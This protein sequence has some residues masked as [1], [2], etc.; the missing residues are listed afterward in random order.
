MNLLDVDLEKSCESLCVDVE[1][2]LSSKQVLINRKGFCSDAGLVTKKRRYPLRHIFDD[3][4]RVLFI[5][6]SVAS[7]YVYEDKDGISALIIFALGLSSINLFL[8][9]ASKRND[10]AKKTKHIYYSTVKRDG[11]IKRIHNEDLVPGDILLLKK[12][13]YVPCD[14][15]IISMDELRVL[16]FG[17]GDKIATADKLMYQQVK[18]LSPDMAEIPYHKC[19]LFAD[20][21]VING[22][23]EAIVMNT[24]SDIYDKDGNVRL[25]ADD[26]MPKIYKNAVFISKQLSVIW[27]LMALLYFASGIFF[28]IDIF[29]SFR[30][31][32]V[33]AVASASDMISGICEIALFRQIRKLSDK[34]VYIKRLS[35]LDFLGDVNCITLHSSA[36]LYNG[37]FYLN[38]YLAD[39]TPH[40]FKD[41]PQ[42]ARELLLGSVLTVSKDR[43]NA[44]KF[45][46]KNID[47]A[48]LKVAKDIGIGNDT[49]KDYIPIKRS[50]HS[51][52]TEMS[53]GLYLNSSNAFLYVRGKPENIVSRC[54]YIYKEGKDVFMNESDKLRMLSAA[55][56]LSDANEYVI[57]VARRA[58]DSAP[59][60]DAE[61][62]LYDLS[63]VGFMGL[64]TPINAEAAKAVNLCSKHNISILLMTSGD[65]DAAYGLARSVSAVQPGDAEYA[66]TPYEYTRNDYGLF[67]ADLQKYKVFC[68]LMPSEEKEIISAHQKDKDI[69]ASMISG[70]DGIIPQ[71]QTDVSF[72]AL[73]ESCDAV[74]KNA[75]VLTMKKD[76]S[77]VPLCIR[78]VQN[79]FNNITKIIKYMLYWQI[80]L[81]SLAFVTLMSER[82]IMFNS[83]SVLILIFFVVLPS[84]IAM[85]YDDM[86]PG[87]LRKKIDSSA[88]K[89]N[90]VDFFVI[91]IFSGI[92]TAIVA[93]IVYRGALLLTSSIESAST[94]FIISLFCSVYF[95][96]LSIRKD[97]RIYEVEKRFNVLYLIPAILGVLYI[98]LNFIFKDLNSATG[99]YSVSW[100]FVVIS[101]LSGMITPAFCD[102][103]K[104]IDINFKKH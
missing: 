64:Y 15:V 46:N 61:E 34:R 59:A 94:A 91:P 98:A 54:G 100:I 56:D 51:S 67:I 58:F 27:I 37:D 83:A 86:K 40:F 66:V 72:A 73:S 36:F 41:D 55:K 20:T 3:V 77:A 63:L 33:L 92:A 1:N 99:V 39:D 90:R 57:A 96:A 44:P 25:D 47:H 74:L 89:I 60:S 6:V 29:N 62:L 42:N 102:I 53:Y 13:S 78:A 26:E 31:A 71:A 49:V 5:I 21:I 22:E 28:N 24:G 103:S 18:A 97:K 79:V 85:A 32:C 14:G 35:A 23:A 65:P 9:L 87:A 69:V 70:I 38:K 68:N 43:R 48:L 10:H 7:Y 17:S 52:V 19:L 12:G 76:V 80:S 101:V 84:A 93:E 104:S 11:R 2:G 30:Y 82:T 16:E 4:M 95:V 45:N 8:A 75:D 81:L 88:M 50:D